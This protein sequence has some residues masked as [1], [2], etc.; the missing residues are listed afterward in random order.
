M[1][2]LWPHGF[3]CVLRVLI[4]LQSMIM[5]SAGEA[6]D[7]RVVWSFVEQ[8]FMLPSHAEPG[9]LHLGFWVQGVRF[10]GYRVPKYEGVV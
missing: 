10:L 3:S 2:L 1:D 5:S 9:A 6:V 4:C 8:P 7:A